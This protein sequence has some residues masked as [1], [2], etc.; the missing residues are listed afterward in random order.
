VAPIAFALGDEDR[1]LGLRERILALPVLVAVVPAIVWRQG[2][3]VREAIRRLD[4]RGLL[5]APRGLRVRQHARGRRPR[6]LP[7]A[8]FA[9]LWATLAPT[10]AGRFTPVGRVR[11]AP[12]P[13]R[14]GTLEPVLD[15]ATTLP[16]QPRRDPDPA[17]NDQRCRD[18]SMASRTPGTMLVLDA[19]AYR[20]PFVDWLTA[21]VGGFVGRARPCAPRRWGEGCPP[22]RG[23]A[24][25]SCN[26]GGIAPLPAP[27]RC[28]R[29]RSGSGSPGAPT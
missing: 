12:G 2:P 11:G 13:A 20:F 23:G 15:L 14:D 7:A 28:A 1:R 3:A 21:H 6:T 22:R 9:G 27:T 25:G 29:A 4:Q 16:R 24:P 8:L 5:R 17:A 26:G 10:L 19:P 18:R